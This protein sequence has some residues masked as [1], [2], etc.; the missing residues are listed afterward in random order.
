MN[1]SNGVHGVLLCSTTW[2]VNGENKV[3][4]KVNEVTGVVFYVLIQTGMLT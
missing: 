3:L 1:S 4:V 2:L